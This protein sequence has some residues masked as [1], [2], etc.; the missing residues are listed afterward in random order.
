MTRRHPKTTGRAALPTVVQELLCWDM[1]LQRAREV[2]VHMG[3]QWGVAG[4][5]RHPCWVRAGV[6]WHRAI[7]AVRRAHRVDSH[8]I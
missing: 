1:P 8:G 5:V 2:G 7:Q 3:D 6:P 4:P